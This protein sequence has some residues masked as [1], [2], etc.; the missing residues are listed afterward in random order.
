MTYQDNQVSW[1]NKLLSYFPGYPQW[2]FEGGFA[3]IIGFFT[4]FIV[5][6]FG[7]P[8]LY[9]LVTLI[10]AGFILHYFGLIDLHFEKFKAM[11]GIT[12][13]PTLDVAFTNVLTWMKEHIALCIGAGV[14]FV[15]GWRM[16]S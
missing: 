8:L 7:K 16:G 13:I 11:M 15:F 3:V 10:V 5:K 9:G 1:W 6:I 2:I 14:G 12:E 4:G